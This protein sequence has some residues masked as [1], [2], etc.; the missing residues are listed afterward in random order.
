M[1]LIAAKLQFLLGVLEIWIN[2]IENKILR[3]DSISCAIVHNF[4][5][6]HF[7]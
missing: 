7:C 5:Y 1:I 4:S 3:I 2:L 6:T